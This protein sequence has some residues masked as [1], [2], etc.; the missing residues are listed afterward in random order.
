MTLILSAITENLAVIASDGAEFQYKE[1]GARYMVE[2]HRQKLFPIPGRSIVLAAHGENRFAAPGGNLDSRRL[3]GEVFDDLTKKLQPTT[4]VEKTACSLLDLL[5]ADV[6]HTFELLKHEW[7]DYKTVLGICVIGFDGTGGNTRGFEVYWP[8]IGEQECPQVIPLFQ[9]APVI[10]AGS[11]KKYAELVIQRFSDKFG[12]QKLRRASERQ[13]QAY[14]RGVY[15]SAQKLQGQGAR[16]FG[17]QYREVTVTQDGWKW[18]AP[19]CT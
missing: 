14:V 16:E 6:N 17:G 10:Y 7:P 3:I 9:G 4:T 18:T 19:N 11:G 5:G 1:D 2:E 15:Q 8:R 13:A 12:P